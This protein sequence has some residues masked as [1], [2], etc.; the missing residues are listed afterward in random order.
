MKIRENTRIVTLEGREL[1]LRIRWN[2]RARRMILRLDTNE[3][4]AL[5]TLPSRVGEREGLLLVE[6]KADWIFRKLDSLPPKILFKNGTQIPYLGRRYI[7]CHDPDQKKIAIKTE[8]E[9]RMG[10]RPEHLSRRLGDWLRREAKT[11]IQPKAINMAAKL[12]KTIGCVSIRDTKSRW[13]S[14]A[15]NG[16]LSFCWRLIMS[17]EWVI[18]YVVAHEVAH[19]SHMNHGKEFWQTVSSLNVSVVSARTWLK[20]NAEQLHRYG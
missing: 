1:L 6:E 9:I 10:G 16:N 14:C 20:Q 15:P 5:V 7:I 11:V 13:G 4:G 12:D 3:G 8:N 19:L 17:P 18:N 2:A